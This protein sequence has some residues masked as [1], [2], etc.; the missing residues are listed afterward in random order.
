M[1][2]GDVAVGQHGRRE[3]RVGDGVADG[4]VALGP[5]LARL[6]DDALVVG[7][8]IR[9]DLQ[10]EPGA[11]VVQARAL[12]G[13]EVHRVA[14]PRLHLCEPAVVAL[15]AMAGI[16]VDLSALGGELGDELLEVPGC[17]ASSSKGQLTIQ[18]VFSHPSS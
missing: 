7:R 13:Q 11:N 8:E 16:G 14:D 12:L 1:L 3:R 18:Q 9:E 4:D 15:A 10:P 17:A 2:A 5:R 6:G